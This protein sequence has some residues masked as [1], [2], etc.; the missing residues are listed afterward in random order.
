MKIGKY[1][2]KT[3]QQLLDSGWRVEDPNG[4]LKHANS[5]YWI[6]ISKGVDSMDELFGQWVEVVGV[7]EKE[8]VGVSTSNWWITPEMVLNESEVADEFLDKYE[9]KI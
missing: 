3:R 6:Y 5:I 9:G 7:N 8:E 1:K 2:F 4:S